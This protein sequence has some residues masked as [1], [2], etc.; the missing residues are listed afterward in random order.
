MARKPNDADELQPGTDPKEPERSGQ[1]ARPRVRIN[2]PS[3]SGS[4][5]LKIAI[6]VAIAAVV[7][8]AGLYG[9]HQTE[10][11][12]IRDPLFVLN[13]VEGSADTPT[14]EIHGATHASRR[15]LQQ[16]FS[17]DMG[18]SVYLLPLAERRATLRAVD[19]VKDASIARVW[20]SR[21]LVKIMERKPVAF[22]TLASSRFGLIDED[23]VILPPVADRFHLPVL[24]GVRPS[25]PAPERR[26]R[27][28]RMMRFMQDI[29]TSTEN[30]AEV[31]VS[32]RSNLK[33]T[34]SKEGRMV[35][36][37]LGDQ[38]HGVRYKNFLNHY[39]EIKQK[40]PDAK[41]LDLRMEDRITV[42]EE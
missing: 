2:N 6:R 24:K 42:V 32:E 9:F 34:Q 25:D 5:R 16:V 31:D 7:L 27:V 22:V 8:V 37:L 35:T 4:A 39:A 3:Q 33:V 29:D 12:L 15:A 1:N 11:F 38:N 36:L 13:G 28:H 23:G 40:L 17:D 41:T 30:V 14:L 10:Q 26:D 20:P 18:R 19:W 21:I